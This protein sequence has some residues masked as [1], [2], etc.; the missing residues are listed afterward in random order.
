MLKTEFLT[1]RRVSSVLHNYLSLKFSLW[2]QENQKE[3]NTLVK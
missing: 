3:T 1:I 2:L